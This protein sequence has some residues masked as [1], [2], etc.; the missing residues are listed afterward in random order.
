[1][2]LI[3][4]PVGG[5]DDLVD[6]HDQCAADGV[7]DGAEPLVEEGRDVGGSLQVGDQPGLWFSRHLIGCRL[8]RFRCLFRLTTFE[9]KGGADL[10]AAVCLHLGVHLLIFIVAH[11]HL[12]VAVD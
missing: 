7:E 3:C 11:F 10:F 5:E 2:G 1:M 4:L 12:T 9:V 6:E 8:N